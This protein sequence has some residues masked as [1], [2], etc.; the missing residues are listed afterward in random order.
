[1]VSSAKILAMILVG[2][3]PATKSSL[4]N[5]D[6][7]VNIIGTSVTATAIIIGGVWAYFKFVKGRTYRPRL[8][9]LLAGQWW[10]V[11]KKWLLQ[12]QV[13]VK[14]VGSSKVELL[15]KGTGLGVGVLAGD[16]P[17]PP[18]S[19]IWTNKKVFVILS[20]QEWLEPGD[21]VSDE[22]LLDLGVHDPSPVILEARLVWRRRLGNVV[23]FQ[24]TMIPADSVAS[25]ARAVEAKTN[26]RLLQKARKKISL[27]TILGTLLRKGL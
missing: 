11:N 9:V 22:L 23:F 27:S 17:P 2:G 15:Q 20:E 16:Q 25:N 8:E 24:R 1:M 7:V 6:A 10:L 26:R 13:T 21:A 5:V 3:D 4:E 19:A 14:N 12:T 18:A